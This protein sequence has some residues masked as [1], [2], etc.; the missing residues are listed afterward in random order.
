MRFSYEVKYSSGIQY[1][2]ERGETTL[3]SIV[4]S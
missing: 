1:G 2:M 4:R 3:E